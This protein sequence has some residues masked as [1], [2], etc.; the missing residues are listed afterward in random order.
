MTRAPIPTRD[1][2]K[3]RGFDGTGRSPRQQGV[4]M[5]LTASRQPTGCS[6]DFLLACGV[7]KSTRSQSNSI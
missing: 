1:S 7:D 2:L 5:G 3:M 4:I 6:A